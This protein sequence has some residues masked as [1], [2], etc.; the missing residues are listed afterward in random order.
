MRTFSTAFIS[1]IFYSNR[2]QSQ[3]QK[4]RYLSGGFMHSV[5]N[6]NIISNV[7]SNSTLSSSDFQKYSPTVYKKLGLTDLNNISESTLNRAQNLYIPIFLYFNK[8]L[9]SSKSNKPLFIGI[10][11][12]QGCGKTTL[13]DIIKELFKVENKKC[14]VMSLDDFYLTGKDQD[15]LAASTSNPLLQYRGNGTP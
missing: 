14:V 10:S 5:D 12:P 9:T 6:N 11:A 4:I 8:L 2:L 3:L 7:I 15:A 1:S 13:T